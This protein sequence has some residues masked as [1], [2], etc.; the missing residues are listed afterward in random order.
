M[1]AVLDG[2]RGGML[3]D[4]DGSIHGEMQHVVLPVVAA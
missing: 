1:R 3:R 2:R 4:R